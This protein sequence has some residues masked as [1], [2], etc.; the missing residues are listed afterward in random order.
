LLRNTMSHQYKE[1]DDTE[2]ALSDDEQTP[3][4]GKEKKASHSKH[5]R[6]KTSVV[7][8]AYFILGGLYVNLRVQYVQL[9]SEV[10]K[11]RPKIFPCRYSIHVLM[12]SF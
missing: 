3:F 6:L 10:L 12:S 11:L 9:E 2:L 8:L 5:Y 4:R 7:V 1:Y